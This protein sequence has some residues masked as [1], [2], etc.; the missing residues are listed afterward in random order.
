MSTFYFSCS[1]GRGVVSIKMHRDS[2][3][4]TCVFASGGIYESR[5]P[6]WSVWA[7]KRRRTIFHGQVGPVPIPQKSTGTCY[8]ELVFLHS[9][10]STGH[11]VHS[12][13]SGA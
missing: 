9:V 3:C 5:S 10:G 6:S 7:I 12:D 1:R 4:W 8:A 11:F 13:A 2:L